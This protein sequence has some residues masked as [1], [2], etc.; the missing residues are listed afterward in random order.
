MRFKATLLQRKSSILL[1]CIQGF[2]KMMKGLPNKQNS[3]FYIKFEKNSLIL[4][5][6]SYCNWDEQIAD[7][8]CR[9]KYEDVFFSEPV[10][11]SKNENIIGISLN[12]EALILPLRSSILAK[13]T[14]LRLSKRDSQNV[15]SFSM[16]IETKKMSTFQLT[17]DCKVDI[18][19]S[20]ITNELI[21]LG[22]DGKRFGSEIPNTHFSLPPPKSLLRL[23]EK[24]KLVDSKYVEI[25]IV[26]DYNNK[27]QNNHDEGSKSQTCHFIC[28]SDKSLNSTVSIKTF[29]NNC[30][31]FHTENNDESR[32]IISQEQNRPT[33]EKELFRVFA[34][35]DINHLM[36]V[37]QFST[38]I[39]DSYCVATITQNKFLSML[40]FFPNIESQI[41]IFLAS[42]NTKTTE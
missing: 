23:F 6:T 12:P 11:E 28:T 16:I 40:I 22:E 20:K 33:D 36:S 8:S 21:P 35:F 4:L 13:E 7:V 31:V 14:T 19:K 32:M 37:I 34:T 17:H 42:V 15:L 30:I 1:E 5:L 2:V 10:L 29:F 9:L 27:A 41:S 25:E 39:S 24:M 38:T 26:Q 3:R 18:L